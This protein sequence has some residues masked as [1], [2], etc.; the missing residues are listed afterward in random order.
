MKRLIPAIVLALALTGCSTLGSVFGI[1]TGT[2]VT[3]A[4][5]YIAANALDAIETTANTYLHLPACATGGPALC[6]QQS[7]V[8]VLV[9]AI[10]IGYTARKNL[11]AAV[12]NGGNAP[13]SLY[14]A[15][16]SQSATLQQIE[17]TY[18]I[19]GSK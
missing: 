19:G 6:R 15:L 3:P 5:A 17:T 2:T 14:T 9:P 13:I 11:I 18:G 12:A 10:R 16:T 7:V 1:V 8:N 4:Q